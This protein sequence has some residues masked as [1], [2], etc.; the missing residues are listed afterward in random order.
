MGGGVW[1]GVRVGLGGKR[2]KGGRGRGKGGVEVTGKVGVG[3]G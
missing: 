1:G 2:G 3:E